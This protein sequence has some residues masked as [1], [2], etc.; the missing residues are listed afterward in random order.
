MYMEYVARIKSSPIAK[1]VKPADLKHKSDLTRLI[2]VIEK[3]L[4][5]VEKYKEAI[6]L[7]LE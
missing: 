6:Q 4:E 1:A 7:L 2:N 5:R 3:D